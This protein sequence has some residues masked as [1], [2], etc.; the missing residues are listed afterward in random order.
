M[1]DDV[2]PYE[3]DAHTQSRIINMKPEWTKEE[4]EAGGDGFSVAVRH[5]KALP[6]GN[7]WAVYGMVY[8]SHPLF[9]LIRTTDFDDKAL[10][11]LPL[12]GGCT[13]HEWHMDGSYSIKFKEFGA[14]YQHAFNH[15]ARGWETADDAA[16]V[17][18]D[19]E[20]LY[21]ELEQMQGVNHEH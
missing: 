11:G 2:M 18:A 21:K 13:Y 5:W 7:C 20:A 4:W 10:H 17:F 15:E 16:E 1:A 12:N 3:W 8:S 14:D 9:G 6:H 19:A